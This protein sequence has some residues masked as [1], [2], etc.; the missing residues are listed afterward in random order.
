MGS[1]ATTSGM[2]TGLSTAIK[3]VAGKAV[4]IAAVAGLGLQIG[5]QLGNALADDEGPLGGAFRQIVE[6]VASIFGSDGKMMTE[7]Q[8]QALKAR[9]AA[10]KAAVEAELKP[11]TKLLDDANKSLEDSN[12][13]VDT[14]NKKISTIETGGKKVEEATRIFNELSKKT[15]LTAVETEALKNASATLA[16]KYP[17]LNKYIDKN[18][19]ILKISQKQFDKITDKVKRHKKAIEA[20]KEAEQLYANQAPLKKALDDAQ[21]A[22][23]D[24][25]KKMTDYQSTWK[26]TYDDW[27][28]GLVDDA[29][30][31]EANKTMQ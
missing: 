24:A 1:V 25:F 29:T 20:Q 15:H 17:E 7:K 21:K 12:K 30:M 18:N 9:A 28:K 14:F 22:Y 6:S 13:S 10:A 26:K 5:K 4:L 2:A 19:G 31:V 16:K 27:N 11:I 3:G 8:W 23:D